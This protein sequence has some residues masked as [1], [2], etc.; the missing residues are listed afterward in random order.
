M[1]HLRAASAIRTA[2]R[3]TARDRLD[4]TD[5][6]QIARQVADLIAAKHARPP[7]RFVDAAELAELLG[8]ERD[9]VYAHAN[10]LGA[11]RLGGPRGRLRFDLQRVQ[12]TWPAPTKP[13]ETRAA[14]RARRK[15][16]RTSRAVRLIP[17]KSDHPEIISPSSREGR[18]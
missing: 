9:W 11:I 16:S 10:A 1:P 3:S 17:Y 8:V 13:G 14:G 12:E 15:R 7:S 2:A 18:A 6:E 4:P 5:I